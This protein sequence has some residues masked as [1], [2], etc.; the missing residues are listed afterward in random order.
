MSGDLA[1]IQDWRRRLAGTPDDAAIWA[2][3]ARFAMSV[4]QANLANRYARRALAL[5]SADL[6]A[7]LTL[8]M[9]L[10]ESAGKAG[11][12]E[13]LLR[14]AA[15]IADPPSS[16]SSWLADRA[17]ARGDFGEAS[18]RYAQ[19]L[20]AFPLEGE[21]WL[22]SGAVRRAAGTLHASRRDARRSVAIAPRDPE[23]LN[24][25]AK[26]Y[27]AIGA[28]PDAITCFIRALSVAPA[29][30]RIRSRYLVCLAYA[31][32]GEGDRFAAYREWGRRHGG[33][34]E[35]VRTAPMRA[36]G[37]LRIGY[38]SADLRNHS[39][40]RNLIPIVENHDREA[41]EV[42][43]YSASS[44]E[45]S[46][47]RHLQSM[48]HRWRRVDQLSDKSIADLVAAD[49]IDVLV[50]IAGHMEGNRIGVARH[51]AAAVQVAAFD[52]GTSGLSEV[53]YWLTDELLHP[54]AAPAGSEQASESLWRVPCCCVHL[55][56]QE[57]GEPG[58]CPSERMGGITFG[59]FSNPAKITPETIA[60]W[61]E[62][63]RAVPGSRLLL[64]FFGRT[65]D[66]AVTERLTSEF[67][68]LGV[69][70]GRIE[71][72]GEAADRRRHLDLYAEIDIALDTS[73]FNG[74]TTVFEALWMG[75]PVVS[76]V[77]RRFV[78]RMGYNHLARLNLT[79]LAVSKPAEFAAAAAR[80]AIDG[81][82]R[83]ML[84]GR[85][86]TAL[87]SSVLCDG[88]AGARAFET[89]FREMRRRVGQFSARAKPV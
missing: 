23:G 65:N 38:L 10:T 75:V 37:K 62:T 26:T 80:L 71:F 68:R 44:I 39:V 54:L 42:T 20:A 15:T 32:V 53:D 70:S 61:A 28:L 73:P 11:E 29:S 79:D 85:L 86:R 69:A 45:D 72:A 76:Q 57:T 55:R 8:V 25:L 40:A 88:V 83:A 1:L 13:R 81:G 87:S 84:R 43:A 41:V 59:S 47:S 36:D 48:I 6:V 66:R 22:R 3:A 51:R 7:H 74:S 78:S 12:L 63:L 18:R 27:H 2:D 17:A 60:L 77:G 49:G 30:A 34:G 5:R 16:V 52:V 82:R 89:A 19:A 21:I 50:L 35:H 24:E 9:A 56:P 14:R 67:A 58:P 31:S 46:V 33:R 64:R 4:R